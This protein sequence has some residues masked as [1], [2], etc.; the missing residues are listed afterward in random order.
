MDKLIELVNSNWNKN[1]F[2]SL[3]LDKGKVKILVEATNFLD[4]IYE[5]IPLRTR[6]YV[7]K[8]DITK[9]TLPKCLCGN[10]VAINRTY[11]E[12][13][14]RKYCGAECSRCDKT[15]DKQIIKTL[16]NYEFLY[17]EKI[18]KQK[19]IEQIA[20]EYNIS[21]VPVIKYLKKHN[22]YQL[23]DARRRNNKA[24]QILENKEILLSLYHTNTMQEIAES[25]GT[26]KSTVSRWCEIHN[27]QAKPSNSYERKVKKISIE[28]NKLY[29]FISSIYGGQI[30]QSNRSILSGKELDIYIPDKKIAIEYNGLYSHCYRPW[31]NKEGLIKN[32]RYHLHKT[33][34]C[35]KQFIQ[36]LQFY[37]DE[38]N[39]KNDIVKN[40]IRSKLG[41]NDKI[42]ARKCEVLEIDTHSK[43]EFLNHYHIQG[44]DKSSIKL[45]LKFDGDLVCIMTFAKSRFNKFYTWELTRFCVKGG[46]SVIGG[47]SKLLKVF[48]TTYDGPIISY[49]DRRYSN[50]NVYKINGFELIGINKPSYYYVDKNFIRRVNRMKFQKKYIG[51][52]D[53]TEYEKAREMGFEK[54]W[55]CGTLA[56]GIR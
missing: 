49:A 16:D 53:C 44:E 50:G 48:R 6:A 28:E 9:E 34:E 10:P 11:S 5:K 42:Y 20:K 55:D 1:D 2:I 13:G 40:I 32:I 27:I 39:Y 17:E 21:T 37:S 4:E 3:S 22:L 15:I 46:I 56:F 29:E 38:W 51:A 35:E 23:N 25:L 24:N 54:I 43:N 18:T 26:T 33:V 52:Y 36:L 31:E 47:F 41:L 45:G 19:S 8:H 14:F 30:Q 7:I 12:L